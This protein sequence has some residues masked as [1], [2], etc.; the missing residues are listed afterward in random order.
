MARIKGKTKVSVKK[1]PVKA[2]SSHGKD[3][4][5]V[6]TSKVAAIVNKKK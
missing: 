4:G 3:T 6:L 1:K 5:G 2:G